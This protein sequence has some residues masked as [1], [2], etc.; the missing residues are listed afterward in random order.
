MEVSSKVTEAVLLS[1][2]I[3]PLIE[4][5]RSPDPIEGIY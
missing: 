4:P 2:L 1:S 5:R 3:T